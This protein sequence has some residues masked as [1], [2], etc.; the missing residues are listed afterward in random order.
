[1]NNLPKRPVRFQ[2]DNKDLLK[3]M[4]ADYRDIE[5]KTDYVN[6]TS[7]PTVPAGVQ[8]NYRVDSGRVNGN[9]MFR[10]YLNGSLDMDYAC[11]QVI[12]AVHRVK[13]GAAPLYSQEAVALQV[14]FPMSFHGELD[15]SMVAA[16]ASVNLSL[17]PEETAMI[18]M[19]VAAHLSE[20]MNYNAGLGGGSTP[21]RSQT[22]TA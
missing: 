18:R 22:K 4:G 10:R 15:P 2:E 20:E 1:M 17:V 7:A 12:D 21:G 11:Q 14:L 19:K 8:S 6:D 5:G 16:V 13:H 3:S 9:E